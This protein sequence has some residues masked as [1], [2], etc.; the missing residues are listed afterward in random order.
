[1][2]GWI[3][4]QLTSE[5]DGLDGMIVAELKGMTVEQSESLRGLL[6][7]QDL[8]MTVVKN[9]LAA[10][11]FEKVGMGPASSLLGGQSAVLYGAADGTITVSRVLSEFTRKM[12]APTV[13]VRGGFLE[14]QLLSKEDAEGLAKLPTRLEMIGIVTG[15][16]R[17]PG[18]RVAG[19]LAGPGARLAGCIQ[20]LVEKLEKEGGG[21]AG[22]DAAGEPA[23]APGTAE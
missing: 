5:L 13:E 9:S 19:A 11:A 3:V 14:G 17:S 7:D 2:K 1:M 10:R 20:S 8:H 16:A 15:Q 21:Q 18:A 22:G 4:D 6:A 12:K 23:E